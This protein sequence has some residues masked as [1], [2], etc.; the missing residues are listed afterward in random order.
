LFADAPDELHKFAASLGLRRWMFQSRDGFPHY[1]LT[2]VRRAMAVEAG[3]VEATARQTVEFARA[4][5][6]TE[7]AAKP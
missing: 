6:R 4:R 2:V 3:A 7:M 5:S 1:D